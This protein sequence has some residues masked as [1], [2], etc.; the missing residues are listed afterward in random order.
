MLYTCAG[1]RGGFVA[2][3]LTCPDCGGW[4]TLHRAPAEPALPRACALAEIPPAPAVRLATHL[5][6]VDRLL[7]GGFV[8]GSTILLVGP[9]GAGKSTLALEVLRSTRLRSLYVSAEETVVQ[10]AE[11]AERL[12][13][14]SQEI[15][16]LADPDIRK[17]LPFA[18]SAGARVVVIDSLQT[19]SMGRPGPP[20]GGPAQIRECLSLLRRAAQAGDLVL[21]L[22]GQVTKDD[23]LAGPRSVEHAADVVLRFGLPAP[24]GAR[25]LAAV[26]NRFGAAPAE[27][28]FTIGGEGLRFAGGAQ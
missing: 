7:G 3:H 20:P 26:K 14:R 8:P 19:V 24:P 1:C 15:F 18:A 22:V 28:A 16:L 9:P 10:L 5:P 23:R 25:T 6:E 11:R 2:F 12:G 13:A 27:C 17:A 21:L 4:D